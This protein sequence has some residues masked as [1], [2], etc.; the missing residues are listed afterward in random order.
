MARVCE[1]WF[2]MGSYKN[3]KE[4]GFYMDDLLKSQ[5]DFL[6]KNI[7][8]DFDF[9]IIIS[10]GGQVRIGK[11]VLAMQIACYWT[12]QMEK[13]HGKKVKFDLD[14][15]IFDGRKLIERGNFLGQNHPYSPLIF[16]EAGADLEG[17]KSMQTITQDVLDYF[18][19]CGQYNMLNILVLPEFFD[20]PRGIA[21]SRSVALLDVYMSIDNEGNFNRG[22]FKFYSRKNKK[23][24][25]LK[26][27]RELNYNAALFDFQGRFYD[28]YPI[29]KQEYSKL[30]VEALRKRESKRRNKFQMQRDAAWWF[31]YK[32]LGWSM[33]SICDKMEQ[34]TGWYVPRTTFMDAIAHFTM[35]NEG[36]TIVD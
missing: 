6:L 29:N 32:G 3:Q 31:M 21:Q 27:K 22:Y 24:L 2:P 9:T 11:S 8:N 7:V 12:Y 15:F 16:D 33:Q 18:R 1:E 5:I 13:V 20:L 23:N 4:I 17:R 35:E 10:G 25:Y 14:T 28:V 34:L 26:G 19:E 36:K 30:K